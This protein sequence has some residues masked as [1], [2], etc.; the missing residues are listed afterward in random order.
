MTL[1]LIAQLNQSKNKLSDT[2]QISIGL[3]AS[4]HNTVEYIFI[5][6]CDEFAHGKNNIF[7]YMRQINYV[8]VHFKIIASLGD[9]PEMRSIN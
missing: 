3:K 7:Y 1:S 5:Q 8:Y 2:Y 4:E 9:Q 6:E